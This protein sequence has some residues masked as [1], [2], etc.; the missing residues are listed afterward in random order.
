MIKKA[1][2]FLRPAL[3][4]AMCAAAGGAA[5]KQVAVPDPTNMK[6]YVDAA[7]QP[8]VANT[9]EGSLWMNN[10]YRS[11]L[12]RDPKARYIN[13]IVTIQVSESITALVTADS[14]TAKTSDNTQSF[15]NLF[16]LE[17][18]IKE[19]P[20]LVSGS[21][22]SDFEGTGTT[23]RATTLLTNM[24]ARVVDVLPNGYLVIEGMRQIHV[25]NE[26]QNLYLTGVV[27]PADISAGNVVPSSAVAQMQVR[28]EGK[29]IVSQ[30]MKQGWLFKILDGIL[31]F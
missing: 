28:V 30:P 22:K 31:P 23:S 24:T 20:N 1:G 13:D 11:D 2:K 29:G 16:G 5:K 25:N 19:L 7:K 14:K 12:F 3:A 26:K 6:A 10:A 9:T 18:K 4:V 21:G 17:K 15:S 27:R 8:S